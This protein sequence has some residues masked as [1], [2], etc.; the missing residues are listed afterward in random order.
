MSSKPELTS[1]PHF[2][3]I[4]SCLARLPVTAIVTA[5][6]MVDQ[7]RVDE[8]SRGYGVSPPTEI[9][10]SRFYAKQLEGLGL[11]SEVLEGDSGIRQALRN[12]FEVSPVLFDLVALLEA[13][14]FPNNDASA[15]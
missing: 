3:V 11:I 5:R 2:D 8:Q 13:G 9:P 10:N 6:K 14:D 7:Y 12:R 1:A 4:L 15:V